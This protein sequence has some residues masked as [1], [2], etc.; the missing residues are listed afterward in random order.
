MAKSEYKDVQEQLF[1]YS[2]KLHPIIRK[3]AIDKNAFDALCRNLATAYD[4]DMK[5][6]RDLLADKERI[7]SNAQDEAGNITRRAKEEAQARIERSEIMR[8]AQEKVDILYNRAEELVQR[9]IDEADRQ[10]DEIIESA[11]QEADRIKQET[12]AY[13]ESV[14][15]RMFELIDNSLENMRLYFEGAQQIKDQAEKVF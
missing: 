11:N 5:A 15:E 1:S 12:D 14:T 4:Q 7:I 3:I 9:K 6:S 8:K 2:D 13:V 10:A